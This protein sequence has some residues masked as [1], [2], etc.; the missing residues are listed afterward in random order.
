MYTTINISGPLL[1]WYKKSKRSMP[2]RKTKDPYKIWLSEIMLQQTQV[3]T[4]IPYYNTW[5]ENFPHFKSVAK[6][7]S[8][9]LL[10]IW[11]GLGYYNRCHNFHKA[12]K[13]I[14]KKHNSCLPANIEDF[15]ALPGVG[16]YT[17]AAVYSIVFSYLIPR[18][19][20]PVNK[21]LLSIIAK[22]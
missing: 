17:A 4:V 8:D 5:I 15:M 16:I 21:K 9:S 20:F 6:A 2:W 14:V 22:I 7:H 12:V 10:L 19:F 1:H 13:I 11:E 18:Y 3:K